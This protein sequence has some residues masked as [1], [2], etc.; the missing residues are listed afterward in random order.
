MVQEMA[1]PQV[2]RKRLLRHMKMAENYQKSRQVSHCSVNSTCATH[3]CTFGLNDPKCAQR[4]SECTQEHNSLCSD[5]I[6]IIVTLDE[7]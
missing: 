3:C 2:D 1:I 4:Y 7:L 6:N 5:C